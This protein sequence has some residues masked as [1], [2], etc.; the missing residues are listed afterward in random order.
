MSGYILSILGIVIAGIFIDIIVPTGGINKY[1]KSIYSIF[2][3]AVILSPVIKFFAKSKDLTINYKDYEINEKLMNYIHKKQVE[4][5]EIKIETDLDSNGFSNI[6]IVITFSVKNNELIYNSCLVNLKNMVI[7]KK[8]QH[9]N[10]YEF[11]QEIVQKHTKLI[12]EE[13]KFNG[14]WRKENKV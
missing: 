4:E 10:K 8:N 14:Q 7:D 2:V 5:T 6:D 3:V 1:I 13:I 11:I 9:I 12:K